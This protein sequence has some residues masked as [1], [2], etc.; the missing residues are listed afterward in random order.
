MPSEAFE[1]VKIVIRGIN[2]KRS[3]MEIVFSSLFGG[4][5]FKD[6]LNIRTGLYEPFVYGMVY[7]LSVMGF[8]FI[9]CPLSFL[10]SRKVY[11]A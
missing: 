6:P 3:F 8:F 10:G 2:H 5:P 4:I 11:G 9:R 7:Q 1:T